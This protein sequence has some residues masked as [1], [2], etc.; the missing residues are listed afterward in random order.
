MSAG[1]QSVG[2][3]MQNAQQNLLIHPNP[4]RRTTDDRCTTC[5]RWLFTG[6]TMIS[7]LMIM[8]C[9]EEG[10]YG[11]NQEPSSHEFCKMICQGEWIIAGI[12][13]GVTAGVLW[14][15]RCI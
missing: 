8:S 6:G 1:A 13:S 2:E 3:G 11:T 9:A 5:A 7:G 4:R 10:C 15:I 14:C 12:V